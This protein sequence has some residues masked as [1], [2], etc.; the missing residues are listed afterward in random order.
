VRHEGTKQV[1]LRELVN[2]TMLAYVLLKVRPGKESEVACEVVKVRGI[3]EAAWTHG[4]CDILLKANVGSVEELD[5]IVLKTI[6]KIHGVQST[7]TMIVSPI[8]IY[9][10]RPSAKFFGKAETKS[11]SSKR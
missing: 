1:K 7:E 10:S 3:T 5:E 4:F 9:G 8:P 2:P 11:R 6:R